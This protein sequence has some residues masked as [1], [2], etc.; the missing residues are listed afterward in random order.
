[1]RQTQRVDYARRIDAALRQLE[2]CIAS[3]EAPGLDRLAATAAL[4]PFHFHRVFRLMTGESVGAAITR[5]RLAHA[6]P[7]LD[8]P[9]LED[10]T[11]RS[12]YGTAQAFARALKD[13]TGNTPSALRVN[14]ERRQQLAA[15]LSEPQATEADP[16]PALKITVASTAPLQLVAIRNV[17]D[18][19]ELNRGY[20]QLFDRVLAQLPMEA[21]LGL[22]G[23]P[24]DDPRDT[25][26]EQCRF[27][28]ALQLDAIAVTDEVLRTLHLAGGACLA[29]EH[30]GDYDQIHD[31]LDL[32][33]HC[34]IE[35][36]LE[37][38]A[39]PLYIHY[40]DDPEQVAT[41]DLRAIAYL[42]VVAA[43]T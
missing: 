15:L 20:G 16:M 10:A 22:Y 12:G 23:L 8:A 4:S 38:G 32:L 37:I 14:R 17:G 33:Y 29:M 41:P 18:Y 26:A 21:V 3:G 39:G 30:H 24:H 7:A 36:D 28:C 27:D 43:C 1:M 2:A 6:L 5:I 13:Q 25:P 34:A 40:L 9:T 19:R 31:A 42:P 11:A 35:Q